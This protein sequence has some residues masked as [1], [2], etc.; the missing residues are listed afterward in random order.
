MTCGQLNGN[1]ALVTPWEAAV[2]N[3]L[4]VLAP[5]RVAKMHTVQVV[6]PFQTLVVFEELGA[7]REVLDKPE[8][9][10]SAHECQQSFDDENPGPSIFVC[11]KNASVN[12]A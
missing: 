7:R 12:V 6:L 4:T 1:S 9:R 11:F 3:R 2:I 10:D 8:T 5:V